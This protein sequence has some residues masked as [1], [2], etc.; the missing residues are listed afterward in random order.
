MGAELV[1]QPDAPLRVAE[2]DQPLAEQLHAHRRAVRPRQLLG[3]HRW[4]P[5]AA[6]QLAHRRARIGAAEIFVLFV[7][8]HGVRV[9]A[10]V[11]IVQLLRLYA[12]SWRTASS[13]NELSITCSTVTCPL[14][15]PRDL[16]NS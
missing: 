6:K 15:R 9:R 4:N 7:G 11:L 2:R 16:K 12:P 1:H 5:V 3:E 14:I 8:D 10:R 13:T